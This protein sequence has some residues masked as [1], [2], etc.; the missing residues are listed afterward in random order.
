MDAVLLPGCSFANRMQA[1]LMSTPVSCTPT[2]VSCSPGFHHPQVVAAAAS[3]SP[4]PVWGFEK[5]Y[6]CQEERKP[7][8]CNGMPAEP[9]VDDI[10][11]LHVFFISSN[12]IS[13]R[14]S[15]S[16]LYERWFQFTVMQQLQ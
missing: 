6:F 13:L 3:Q 11:F 9:C 10:Q 8:S 2:V 5:V 1:S 15:N 14:S 7:F 4:S 16:F 12:G